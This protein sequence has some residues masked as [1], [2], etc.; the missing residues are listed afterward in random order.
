M[1]HWRQIL[2]RKKT[3]KSKNRSDWSWNVN[4]LLSEDKSQSQRTKCQ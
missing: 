1:K 4:L 3:V 2:E